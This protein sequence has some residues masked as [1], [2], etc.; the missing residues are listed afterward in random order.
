MAT[1]FSTSIIPIPL[2]SDNYAWRVSTPSGVVLVDPADAGPALASLG[3]DKLVGVLSTHYHNDH[4]GDNDALA[5]AI[6]GLVVVGGIAEDGR[7]PA[8]SRGVRD[9]DVVELA[10]LKFECLHTPCHTR[11]HMMYYVSSTDSGGVL[12]TGDT[13]FAGGCGR[14]FEGGPADMLA[15]LSR[16]GSLPP[17]TRVYCGHEYT[18]AN[19]QFC[20]TVEPDNAKTAARLAAAIA[21]RAAGCPTVPSTIG[22]ELET[23]V[24]MRTSVPAVV[25]F[26][27][28]GAAAPPNPVEVM[29]RLREAK[30]AF[31]PAPPKV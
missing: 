18:V 24:F 6:P 15:A 2:F 16:V 28:A 3:D 17:D 29:A 30:N 31:K 4:S 21:A 22:E 23:N 7:V 27:H 5:A 19:L 9:G 14:F 25:R 10:G 11:G 1:S 12:F 13:V 8:M 20:A 26:T